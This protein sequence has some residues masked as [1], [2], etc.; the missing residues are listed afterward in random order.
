MKN[1][2]TTLIAGVMPLVALWVAVAPAL[3]A[4]PILQVAFYGDH[5]AWYNS[6]CLYSCPP[7][8]EPYFVAGWYGGHGKYADPPQR[9]DNSITVSFGS[10]DITLT[11]AMSAPDA[12]SSEHRPNWVYGAPACPNAFDR[13]HGLTG[14][15]RTYDSG[16]LLIVIDGLTAG[17]L[18][19][20]DIVGDTSV[21][22]LIYNV[23]GCL[24]TP[25]YNTPNPSPSQYL[26]ATP[27]ATPPGG[28]GA[29]LL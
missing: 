10:I 23:T 22:D 16:Y 11:G 1:N 2:K 19:Q 8:W 18:Y 15:I 6:E 12:I 5:P 13:A 24:G 17:T 20:I 27:G 21:Q 28:G 14:G 25:L 4:A 3:S 26:G 7:G 9:R 29:T